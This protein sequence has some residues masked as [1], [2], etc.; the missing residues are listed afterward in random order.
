M[1]AQCWEMTLALSLT[2]PGLKL[3]V[4]SRFLRIGGIYTP[5]QHPMGFSATRKQ[6]EAVGGGVK[7]K[8]ARKKCFPQRFF[9]TVSYLNANIPVLPS[10]CQIHH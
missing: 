10:S 9:L 4:K 3:V 8:K 6:A 7:D 1:F 2:R 5:E